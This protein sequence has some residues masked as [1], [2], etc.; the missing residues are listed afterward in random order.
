MAREGDFSQVWFLE[1]SDKPEAV[2][3]IYHVAK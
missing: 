1:T 2:G 3:I